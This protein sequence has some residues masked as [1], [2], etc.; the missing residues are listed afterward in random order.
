MDD[1]RERVEAVERAIT[2]GDG[3]LSAL[4]DGA[5][6][7]ERVSDLETAVGS[8][9]NDVAELEAATQ[10]LRGYVGNVRSVNDDVEQRADAA[11]AAVDTLED[12][13]DELAERSQWPA[14]DSRGQHATV[15][16]NCD[17]TRDRPTGAFDTTEPHETVESSGPTDQPGRGCPTCGRESM[18]VTGG[19]T[20]IDEDVNGVRAQTG[21][22]PGRES[23]GSF[24]PDESTGRVSIQHASTGDAEQ[25]DPGV[26]PASQ[27]RTRDETGADG[28]FLDR[29]RELL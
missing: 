23:L 2:D 12:R 25:P 7:A 14:T 24:D 8:L 18:A 15:G 13:V 27:P 20:A 4:A 6:T 11:V 9:R 10:A 5:A 19:R 1:L 26:S 29:A 17:E 16:E 3:D 28:G 21:G 22:R